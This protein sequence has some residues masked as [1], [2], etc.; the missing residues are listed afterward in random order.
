MMTDDEVMRVLERADPARVDET[1]P[2][3]DPA[4]YLDDLRTNRTTVALT[5]EAADLNGRRRWPFIATAAAAVATL[6]VGAVVL[7]ARDGVETDILP[8]SP[9]DPASSEPGETS[10]E[11]GDAATPDK[12]PIIGLRDSLVARSGEILFMVSSPTPSYWRA[13]ALSEFD[14][15]TWRMSDTLLT[16][17]SGPLAPGFEADVDTETVTQTFEIVALNGTLLPAAFTPVRFEGPDDV[18]FDAEGS[19]LV[20][21]SA[22]PDGLEYTV[23]SELPHF[24]PDQLRAADAPPTEISAQ[25]VALPADFPTEL[26]DQARLIT[27]GATTRYDQAIALQ[28]WFREFSYDLSIRSGHDEAAMVEFIAERRG[29]CE[30]F[31]GT[32]AAL[33]R[34]LGL[35]SRVAVGFTAGER[36]ADGRYYVQGTNAHAWPEIYFEGVGWVLFEPTPGRGSPVTPNATGVPPVQYAGAE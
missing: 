18:N 15:T 30:Q 17:T 23:D 33:A 1:V 4:A 16:G 10:P 26:A 32:F 2:M 20:T 9:A 8:A 6:V 24:D 36:R 11:L 25:Y 21:D 27:A 3:V 29:Y 31:A 7:A 5:V 22:A 34:T 13:A 12:S 35:P 28:T 19:I 14:G